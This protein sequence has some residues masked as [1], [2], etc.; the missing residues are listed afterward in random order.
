V[1][2][3]RSRNGILSVILLALILVGLP[4]AALAKDHQGRSIGSLMPCNRPVVPPRCASVGNDVAHYV[5][6]DASVPAALVAAVRRTMAQDYDPTDLRM[7]VQAR[8]SPLTDVIVY[9]G[10]YGENGAAGWVWC[11]P[12]APQGT[13]PQGDRW[14][15]QQELRFNLNPRYAAFFA[16]R[17]SRDY[18]AC[19]ELGHTLG[20]LHWGN[21]P[22]S[23]GPVGATCMNP[24]VPDGPVDLHPADVRHINRYYTVTEPPLCRLRSFDF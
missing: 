6:F 9:A 21:P 15:Q 10:D 20:L 17:G 11:P 16:D 24:D 3:P 22:R 2:R 8:L 5:Y 12:D 23:D 14:C 4:V 13:S 1:Y 18:M 19:H 7:H